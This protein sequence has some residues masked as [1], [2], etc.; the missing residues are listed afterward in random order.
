MELKIKASYFI[1]GTLEG[2]DEY[3]YLIPTEVLAI[4]LMFSLIQTWISEKLHTHT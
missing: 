3:F 1:V 2:Q 4:V